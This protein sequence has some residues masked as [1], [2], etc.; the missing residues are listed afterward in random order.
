MDLLAD[1]RMRTGCSAFL[2]AAH[3]RRI[4]EKRSLYFDVSSSSM[5]PTLSAGDQVLIRPTGPGEPRR[6]QV[7]A[8]WRGFLVTHRY[9]GAGRYR[10]DGV[11]TVDPPV[12]AEDI[13]GIVVGVRRRGH[14]E[15]DSLVRRLP[16]RACL[17]RGRL[18]LHQ[19]ARLVGRG[20]RWAKNS[21]FRQRHLAR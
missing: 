20:C 11:L 7:V 9:L 6:G 15:T 18:R 4:L 2:S 10:G 5:A 16:L 3:W 12:E 8:Y 21:R 19:L 1:A 13:V 14:G 17:H